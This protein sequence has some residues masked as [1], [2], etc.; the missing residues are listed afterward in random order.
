MP[1]Q[2]SRSRK[3]PAPAPSQPRAPVLEGPF[4]ADNPLPDQL[5]VRNGVIVWKDGLGDPPDFYQFEGDTVSV[6]QRDQAQ[7]L[8]DTVA[9]QNLDI[10]VLD[11][12]CKALT[13]KIDNQSSYIADLKARQLALLEAAEKQGSMVVRIEQLERD[14]RDERAM[15]TALG[16]AIEFLGKGLGTR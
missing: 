7:E 11:T 8:L 4:N 14:L 9:Q 10:A 3:K 13:D 1:K 16:N 12:K 5:I 6:L 2:K 15:R